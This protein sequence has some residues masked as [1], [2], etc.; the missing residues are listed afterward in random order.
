[1]HRNEY[2]GYGYGKIIE[3]EKVPQTVAFGCGYL[4]IRINL[5][6]L[7]IC[8][9]YVNYDKIYGKVLRM[10]KYVKLLHLDADI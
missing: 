4:N 5:D 2:I 8:V 6:L 7:W 3:C 1:M 10:K 9:K